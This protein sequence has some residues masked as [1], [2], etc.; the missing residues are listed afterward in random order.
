MSPLAHD[1]ILV[2]TRSIPIGHE[3][4]ACPARLGIHFEFGEHTMQIDKRFTLCDADI[5]ARR[6]VSRRSLL[7][8]LG[9]GVGL[10]AATVTGAATL[11]RAQRGSD[12]CERDKD[13]T[14]PKMRCDND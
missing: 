12:R 4:V 13:P 11:L 2:K 7:G 1:L 6:A 9:I 5:S 14:D 3:I 8:R 10:G